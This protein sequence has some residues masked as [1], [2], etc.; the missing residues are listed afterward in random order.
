MQCINATFCALLS[1]RR[2]GLQSGAV[3]ETLEKSSEM[4]QNF[5][6]RFSITPINFQCFELGEQ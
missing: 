6:V 4:L 1:E 3:V 2:R 5:W